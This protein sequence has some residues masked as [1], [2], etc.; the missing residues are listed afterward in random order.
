MNK[1][2][3]SEHKIKGKDITVKKA[4]VKQGKIYVGKLPA[5]G[6]DEEDVENH[7]SQF[8]DVAEVIRPID[9]MKD[10]KP[11]NFCFDTFEKER[12]AKQMIEEGSCT[13]NCSK[14]MIKSVTP[15]PR[16][17]S[18][19]GGMGG[20]MR[21]RGGRGG[22]FGGSP[23]MNQGGGGYGGG[24]WGGG[25]G[26]GAWGGDGGYGGGQGG[27]NNGGNWGGNQGGYGGQMGGGFG[28]G[29]GGFGGNN[30]NFRGGMGGQGGGW[31]NG[32]GKMRGGRGGGGGKF[33]QTCSN[34]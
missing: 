14:M 17:P 26:G 20:G 1:A 23:W 27:F 18:A 5:S 21:G 15:N 9:K 34:L 2:A 8:G 30:G 25:Y 12:V 7:F 32:G 10:N 6:V 28:G 11:K 33:I 29:Q 24:G 4:D 19:R 16:D 13:I 31:S 22:N 3:E